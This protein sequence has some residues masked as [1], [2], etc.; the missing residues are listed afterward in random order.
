M[1]EP[2][3]PKYSWWS[4]QGPEDLQCDRDCMKSWWW[5]HHG[6]S[7][8]CKKGEV[9]HH[10][11]FYSHPDKS[12]QS[13]KKEDWSHSAVVSKVILPKISRDFE[14]AV[15]GR[16]KGLN[17]PWCL[18]HQLLIQSRSYCRSSGPWWDHQ[19]IVYT[20]DDTSHINWAGWS[21]KELISAVGVNTVKILILKAD[22]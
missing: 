4:H 19:L 13:Y 3:V 8:P 5:R 12:W 1:S 9:H 7:H 6:V 22:M 11:S 15:S 16:G 14:L 17:T 20:I 21:V 10:C 2:E 18:H